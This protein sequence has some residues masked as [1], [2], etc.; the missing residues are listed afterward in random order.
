MRPVRELVLGKGTKA[1]REAS[2]KGTFALMGGFK[3]DEAG[4][5]RMDGILLSTA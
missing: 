4:R 2:R 1:Q 3:N 5:W